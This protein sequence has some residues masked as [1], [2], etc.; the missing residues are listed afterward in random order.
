MWRRR[1][2]DWKAPG[3]SEAERVAVLDVLRGWKE[4]EDFLRMGRKAILR[5]RYPV[6][7]ERGAAMKRP[8]VYAFRGE[9]LE[10]ARR[11][12]PPS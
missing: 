3:K 1:S 12:T 4:I 7:C 10:H 8:S 5:A 2:R 6:R 9:L 11:G